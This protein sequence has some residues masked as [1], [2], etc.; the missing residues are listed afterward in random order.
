MVLYNCGLW[1]AMMWFTVILLNSSIYRER[2]GK[3]S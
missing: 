1:A 2:S 3:R